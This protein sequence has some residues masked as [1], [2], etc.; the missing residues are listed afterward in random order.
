MHS[1]ERC[2]NKKSKQTNYP[3]NKHKN[4]LIKRKEIKMNHKLY[5]IKDKASGFT[6]IFVA[7]SKYN[8]LRS[9]SDAVNGQGTVIAQHPEDFSL[10]ELGEMDQ[11]T[12]IISPN[13]S[14]IEEA[15]NLVKK[16]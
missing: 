14:F 5:S 16:A 10:Y 12:G 13:V 9:F 3:T 7:N 4:V 11:D 8:A 6:Q 15:S 2:K 1:N